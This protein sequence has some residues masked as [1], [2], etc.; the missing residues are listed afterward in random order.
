[1]IKRLLYVENM[2][3][4]QPAGRYQYFLKNW[5]KLRNNPLILEL[6]EGYQIPFLSEPSQT[7]PPSSNSMSQEETAIVYQEI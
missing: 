4:I 1:M 7:A 3:N 2:E 6:V 5:G